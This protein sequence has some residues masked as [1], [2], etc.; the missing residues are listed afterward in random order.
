MESGDRDFLAGLTDG[1]EGRDDEAGETGVVEAHDADIARN[2]DADFSEAANESC[3]GV[4]VSADDRIRA[5]G[6]Y[7]IGEYGVSDIAAFGG[8]KA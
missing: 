4:V 6:G 8:E 2:G 7:L 5:V 1:R 3:G